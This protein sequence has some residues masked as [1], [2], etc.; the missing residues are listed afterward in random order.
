MKLSEKK[1]F[2]QGPLQFLGMHMCVHAHT[3]ICVFVCFLSSFW[4]V[5]CT[6]LGSDPLGH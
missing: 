3:C 6:E 1:P 4:S 2:E 5:Q